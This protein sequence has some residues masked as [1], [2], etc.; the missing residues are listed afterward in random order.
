MSCETCRMAET[1]YLGFK[2]LQTGH[3]H[4]EPTIF[5]NYIYKN[6]IKTILYV[7]GFKKTSF[8]NRYQTMAA[9][10]VSSSHVVS[11]LLSFSL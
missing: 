4:S 11:G 10:A 7:A 5:E 3:T 1:H 8:Q 9:R 2:K 6:N